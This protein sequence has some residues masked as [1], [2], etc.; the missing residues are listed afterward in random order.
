MNY[1][2]SAVAQDVKA[3]GVREILKLT[4]GDSIISFAGGLPAEEL[5]PKEALRQAFDRVFQQGNRALQYGLTE[6]YT[7][8]REAIAMRMGQKGM[9]VSPSEI[10]LTTG[11]QQAIDLLARVLI[12]PGDVIL[13]EDPTYLSALQIFRYHSAIVESVQTDDDGMD[14]A[15]LE[16]KVLARKPK[17]IYVTP[18]FANPTGRVW[19]TE[20]RQALIALCR[21]HDV[22]IVE[23]DPYGEIKF[24]PSASYPSIYSL[25]ARDGGGAVVYTSTF[26][27]TVVPALRIG[28]AMGHPTMIDAMARAKQA[29]DL[30]S[31]SLDQQALFQLLNHFDIDLHITAIRMEYKKRMWLMHDLL[32]QK[33]W[34]GVRWNKPAGGMFL[35]MTLPEGVVAEDLL[36][37][38]VR[39]GVAFVP[40]AEFF[41]G[42]PVKNTLRLNFS[43]SSPQALEAGVER[44]D[45]SLQHYLNESNRTPILT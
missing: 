9:P 42:A 31:S 7:P 12:E 14:M 45:R 23:D 8:L 39:E 41:C 4:Q 37:V 25:D 18:T 22:L 28:W 6:G 15:A 17:F 20:R 35:W 44:L 2:L 13:V 11:S 3:S 16:R 1:R 29:V 26:S 30:H 32:T 27:K 19:S 36:H 34:D 33:R 38:A 40:G 10:V 21:Q 43:H 5:F 24:D